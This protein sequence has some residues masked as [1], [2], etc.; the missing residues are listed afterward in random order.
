MQRSSRQVRPD[1][2][3][4]AAD[5]ALAS[6]DA[7]YPELKKIARARLHAARHGAPGLNTTTQVHESFLRL[8]GRLP[9]LQFDSRGRFY[10]GWPSGPTAPMPARWR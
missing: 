4:A 1:A 10:S 3:D 5:A 6:W 9:T 2:H 7:A 8:A